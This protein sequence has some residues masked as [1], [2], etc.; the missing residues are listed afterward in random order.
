MIV[1][2]L[3]FHL[4][5]RVCTWPPAVYRCISSPQRCHII[6]ELIP[7][8]KQVKQTWVQYLSVAIGPP[9]LNFQ[10]VDF[11]QSTVH[12]CLEGIHDLGAVKINS[13][14]CVCVCVYVLSD[15]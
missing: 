12:Q 10:L 8:T 1:F 11:F 6:K 3:K 5:A 14:V 9:S 7:L 4:S 2:S 15:M 13:Q